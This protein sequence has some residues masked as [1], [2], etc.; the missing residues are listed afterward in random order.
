MATKRTLD[1]RA[2]LRALNYMVQVLIV[3]HPDRA[4]IAA[5]IGATA[6]QVESALPQLSSSS[7]SAFCVNVA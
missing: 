1:P 6:V 5:E 3:T 4:K 2:E 7:P